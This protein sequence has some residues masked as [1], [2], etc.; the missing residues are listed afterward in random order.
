MHLKDY[1]LTEGRG[2][3]SSLSRALE[4]PASLISDWANENRPIPVERCAAIERATNGAVTR[5]DLRPSDW[6]LIWPEL[7]TAPAH[8]AQPAIDSVAAKEAA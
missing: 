6:S 8:K 4:V 7:I 5:R 2:A 3:G 1:L